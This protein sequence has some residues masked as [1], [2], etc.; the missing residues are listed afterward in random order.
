MFLRVRAFLPLE[1]DLLEEK[2]SRLS[3]R[4]NVQVSVTIQIQNRDLHPSSC[5]SAEVDHMLDVR[6]TGRRAIPVQPE[7]F[8]RPGIDIVGQI[9]LTG[10]DI[11]P[12][13]PIHVRQGQG[14][15]LRP[16]VVNQMFLPGTVPVLQPE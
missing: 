11:K 10:D 4:H 5:F 15:S 13:I 12:S 6:R 14:M 8:I 2:E 7:W 9:A 1:I 16:T 3:G